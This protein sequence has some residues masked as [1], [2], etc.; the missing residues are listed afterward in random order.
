MKKYLTLT[1][2]I[3]L[4]FLCSAQTE[5][6]NMNLVSTE[7]IWIKETNASNI[8][9][10]VPGQKES[11]VTYFDGLGRPMQTVVIQGSPRGYD[12]VRPIV[13]DR[14]GREARKY[15]PIVISE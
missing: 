10:L 1:V 5:S 9:S 6:Q 2:S 11:S 12:I 7:T 14:Y 15:L 8:P 3:V 13:Y 4:P